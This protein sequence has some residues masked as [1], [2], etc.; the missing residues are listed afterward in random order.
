MIYITD[1][2]ELKSKFYTFSVSVAD[3]EKQAYTDIKDEKIL[4]K[5]K[6]FGFKFHKLKFGENI[7]KKY[8]YDGD[9]FYS[10]IERRKI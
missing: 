10:L 6:N 2:K 5:L 3:I 7:F 9:Y 8:Y 4:E 1:N